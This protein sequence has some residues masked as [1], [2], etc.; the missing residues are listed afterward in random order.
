MLSAAHFD[1]RASTA[2][3]EIPDLPISA[4]LASQFLE[5]AETK[6][7]PRVLDVSA[8]GWS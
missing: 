2:A 6:Q 7:K 4:N 8:R 1:S 3:A 5:T